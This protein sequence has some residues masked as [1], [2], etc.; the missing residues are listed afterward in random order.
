MS[1]VNNI[2]QGDGRGIGFATVK[3]GYKTYKSPYGPDY[4]IQPNIRGIG[5]GRAMKF[6]ITAASFGV[7]GAV[8]ALQFFS[9]V[10]KV[11]TDICQKLPLIGDYFVKDIPP[12]DNVSSPLPAVQRYSS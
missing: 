5:P 6:G 12:S 11:R 1:S 7:V 10:P 8:F 4:K 2:V 3:P 9:D